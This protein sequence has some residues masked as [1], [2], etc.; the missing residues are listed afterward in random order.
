VI[1]GPRHPTG[2]RVRFRRRGDHVVASFT[3]RRRHQGFH[4]LM[5]GGLLA[6]IFDCLHYRIPV[7]AGVPHAVTA[8]V[9]VD[10][11]APIPV[12]ARVRFKAWLIARRGRV[13]ESG[14]VAVLP[15]GKVA[16]ESRAVYVEVPPERLP[17]AARRGG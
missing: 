4:G 1:C 12:G 11:R 6:G 15:G 2:L 10:Y 14:A 13:F 3:P 7:A 16:A 9:E 8:R 17:P 5:S